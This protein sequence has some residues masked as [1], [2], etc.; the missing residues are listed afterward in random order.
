[1]LCGLFGTHQMHR[2]Y[3]DQ[4]IGL[5][6][7]VRTY[8][9]MNALMMTNRT[10]FITDTYVNPDP[11]AEQLA[12]ITLLA[13]EEIRR[14]GITPKVAL[15]SH[16]TFGTSDQPSASKMRHA[17]ALVNAMDPDLEVDGE[18]H[19]DSALSEEV[20]LGMFPNARLKGECAC[21]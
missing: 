1:M 16:S 15:L 18:M 3:I 11:T 13:A 5:K 2:R 10:V 8:A 9:A 7:G 20:R 12:E 17:L 14:F 4:V 21:S 19:G 6:R